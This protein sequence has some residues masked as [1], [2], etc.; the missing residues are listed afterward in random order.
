MLA[1]FPDAKLV[2]I[3]RELPSVIRSWS[4]LTEVFRNGYS[5]ET[6]PKRIGPENSRVGQTI[7][8]WFPGSGYER[9]PRLI[10]MG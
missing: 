6:D 3:H 5:D 10:A 9:S 8:S 2:Q 1:A 4:S 7:E